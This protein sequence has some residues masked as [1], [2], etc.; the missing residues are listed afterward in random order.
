M[1]RL[2]ELAGAISTVLSASP[3]PEPLP[4]DLKNHSPAEATVFVRAVV[5]ACQR[6]ATPLFEVRISPQLGASLL[7]QHAGEIEGIRLTED[8]GL[9]TSIEFFRFPSAA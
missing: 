2:D 4:V 3:T 9:H 7:R 6:S 8:A 1:A 5:E